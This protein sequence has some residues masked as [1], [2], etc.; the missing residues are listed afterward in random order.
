[1]YVCLHL[2]RH[3]DVFFGYLVK[4]KHEY[5]QSNLLNVNV[6]IHEY[7]ELSIVFS[8]FLNVVFYHSNELEHSG[9]RNNDILIV[10]VVAFRVKI[11]VR[12]MTNIYL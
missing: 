6:Q 11:H 1:M 8:E 5:N 3:D 12:V 4:E 7:L 9:S 2:R 10:I